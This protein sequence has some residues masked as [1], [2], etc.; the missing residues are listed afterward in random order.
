MK[1][2]MKE[3]KNDPVNCLERRRGGKGS[4]VRSR[5]LARKNGETD[6]LGK[7]LPE[8]KDGRCERPA[9]KTLKA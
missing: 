6:N 4:S 2:T 3:R 1:P 8:T 9:S 7:K 5:R